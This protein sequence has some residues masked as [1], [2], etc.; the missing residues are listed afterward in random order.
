MR[1]N[2][3]AS[4]HLRGEQTEAW[5]VKG[6]Y[7]SHA[8]CRATPPFVHRLCMVTQEVPPW[9]G[10][11][12]PL[13][14]YSHKITLH[15]PGTALEAG[16]PKAVLSQPHCH[17]PVVPGRESQLLSDAPP[18]PNTPTIEPISSLYS[19]NETQVPQAQS[20]GRQ[21]FHPGVLALATHKYRCLRRREAIRAAKREMGQSGGGRVCAR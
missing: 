9:K 20:G 4:F 2:Y 17:R 13:Y 10:L 5:Q 15:W 18:F 3:W 11:G 6:L 1:S 7:Q 8:G 14:N 16:G 12:G 19:M 21:D